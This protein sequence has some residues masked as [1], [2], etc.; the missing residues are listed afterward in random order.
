MKI[1]FP[2]RTFSHISSDSHFMEIYLE[3]VKDIPFLTKLN[4]YIVELQRI[5]AKSI[6]FVQ[7]NF[8]L[9]TCL[10]ELIFSY[11]W[12]PLLYSFN[13]SND[14][15]SDLSY[16]LF[17]LEFSKWFYQTHIVSLS[18][19]LYIFDEFKTIGPFCFTAPIVFR[20]IYFSFIIEDEENQNH[21][22]S[23]YFFQCSK[24]DK[25][26]I[27]SKENVSPL[28]YYVKIKFARNI[29]NDSLLSVTWE[30]REWHIYRRELDVLTIRKFIL[31]LINPFSCT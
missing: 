8:S 11:L 1:G 10:I 23:A 6:T 15:S 22:L 21:Y 29:L 24:I 31:N 16:L 4:H 5:R 2:F 26:G 9:P 18:D 19:F 25:S 28:D 12:K 27:R 17:L 14:L 13:S 30:N 7:E 20:K 3:K